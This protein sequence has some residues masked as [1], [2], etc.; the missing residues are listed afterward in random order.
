MLQSIVFRLICPVPPYDTQRYVGS[1]KAKD[2]SQNAKEITDVII[3]AGG[4]SV[5]SR[6]YWMLASKMWWSEVLIQIA[7]SS[8]CPEQS[9]LESFQLLE[10][11][12]S[13]IEYPKPSF[14]FAGPSVPHITMAGVAPQTQL[15]ILFGN[16]SPKLFRRPV[17]YFVT[18]KKEERAHSVSW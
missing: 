8:P 3:K 10:S 4:W 6:F 1:Q 5:N 17:I 2:T 9:H 11:F 12:Y 18:Y 13:F 14:T 15:W 7:D 16:K